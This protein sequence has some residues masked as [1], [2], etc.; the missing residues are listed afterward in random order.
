V[1]VYRMISAEKASSPVSMCCAL[2]GVSRSGYY[3]WERRAPS[4]R[5][6]S[7]A[8]LIERIHEIW[9]ENRK[10]YGSPRI[11]AD[12][13]LRYGIRVGRKRVERLMREAGIWA[14]C[15]ANAAGPRSRCR[16]SGSL[17]TSSSDASGLSSPTSSGSPI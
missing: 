12:L 6:L 1:T 10:V 14:W 4:D 9:G 8:W 7:D 17:M 13:R 15:A 11:H 3:D 5:A 16:A 2:L